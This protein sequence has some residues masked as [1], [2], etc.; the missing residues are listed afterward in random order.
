MVNNFRSSCC[1]VCAR[2]FSPFGHLITSFFHHTQISRR[3]DQLSTLR[4]V[5]IA[6]CAYH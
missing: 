4:R 6:V 3:D 5:R 1:C 2:C